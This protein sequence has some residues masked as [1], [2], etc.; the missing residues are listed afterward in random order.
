MKKL[1]QKDSKKSSWNTAAG[2]FQTEGT[3]KVDFILPEFYESKLISWKA[4]VTKQDC[5]YDMIVGRDLL[6][7]LG[8]K[9]D[10]DSNSIEWEG[11]SVP[12]KPHGATRETDL[13]LQDSQAVEEAVD[14]MKHILD[15]KYAKADLDEY[16]QE[17]DYLSAEEKKQL[18]ALL[19]QYES[20]FDG[21][22]GR[23]KNEKYDIELRPNV[24]PYHAKAYP[25]PK[26]YEKTLRMEVERLCKVGVLKKVNRSEWAALPSL[27]L[28]RTRQS[29]S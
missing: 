26:S 11:A 6:Q 20:L 25:I 21:T 5:G 22:L 17:C 2:I 10:F 29:A 9:I 13:Y 7:E 16:V 24:E 18:L 28:R 19:K 1:K 14:R 3:A 12:M 27:Y 15:A 8:M 23:W 4:H